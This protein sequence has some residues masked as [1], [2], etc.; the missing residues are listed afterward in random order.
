M[1][2]LW[3]ILSQS[4]PRY[5]RPRYSLERNSRRNG[6]QTAMHTKWARGEAVEASVPAGRRH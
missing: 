1:A 5:R 4:V 3:E 2:C 6:C